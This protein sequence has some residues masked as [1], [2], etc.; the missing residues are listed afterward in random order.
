MSTRVNVNL[1]FTADTAQAKAQLKDLQ[2]TLNNLSSN[3]IKSAGM[4]GLTK[5]IQQGITAS[6]QLES[7]LSRAT[8]PDTG[9]LNL[10]QFQRGIQSAGLDLNKL[11]QDMQKLGPEGSAAFRDV[12]KA[13][14]NAEVPLQKTNGMM[15]QLWT[16]MKNTMKWQIS[17]AVIQ[18]FTKS[19]GEAF[20]YAKDLNRS[21]NDISIVTGMANEDMDKFAVRANKAAKALSTTTNEYAKASL[22]YYQQGLSGKD[23]EE[24]ANTTV[25]LAN[26]TGES[27]QQVSEWMTAIWNNFDNG[28]KSL[29]YYAD[30]IAN[31]G[32]TT[33]S[34]ADEIATGLEKF[35]AIADTVGLSY[36]YATAALATVTA[37]TRQSA[38]V[39]GTAFKTLFARIQDLELGKALD[40]GTTL[41]QYSQALKQVGVD[42]KNASGEIKSMDVVL[43]E[44]G[45]RW[46]SLAADEKVA[47]AQSVAGIRQYSQMM[48]LMDNWDSFQLNVQTAEISEGALESQQKIYEKSWEASSNRV[49]ASLEGVYDSL[50]NDDL[51]ITLNDS[52]AKLI[53]TFEIF[54]DSI[55]GLAGL[56]PLLFIGL[57]KAFGPKVSLEIRQMSQ[58][59]KD[60][61]KAAQDSALETKKWAAETYANI[62]KNTKFGPQ[63]AAENTVVKGE[64]EIQQKILNISYELT[65]QE[66]DQILALKEKVRITGD[67][68]LK[69]NEE[70]E[71]ARQLT[72]E[73]EK[74]FNSAGNSVVGKENKEAF[75]KAKQ[76][77]VERVTT[78]ATGA[79]D[80]IA[81]NDVS[82]AQA[83]LNN[84]DNSQRIS[85]LIAAAP[86]LEAFIQKLKEADA[87]SEQ[88]QQA[89]EELKKKIDELNPVSKAAKSEIQQLSKQFQELNNKSK[90][91]GKLTDSLTNIGVGIQNN[92]TYSTGINGVEKQFNED[93]EKKRDEKDGSNI[94]RRHP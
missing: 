22:I 9:K 72:I 93:V 18:G 70:K 35:A 89:L 28:S 85:S 67:L 3:K 41:G 80:L 15:S 55:N 32:A 61:S 23:V 56:L 90:I 13:I 24:R 12:T 63:A 82:E 52:L 36:E 66:Q 78:V 6:K 39:V 7:A 30:V 74:I 38:D 31:L 48:A 58:N 62:N 1:A 81:Q 60:N 44:L 64:A 2:T 42:I 37:E 51:F 92:A 20:T 83:Y 50:I 84:N 68:L 19:I 10:T 71:A 17:A 59:L 76:A 79:G 87:A 14:M 46:Q 16:T 94:Q 11:G 45:S 57:N 8:N 47:V 88:G 25:K 53:S 43:N 26:V 86:K 21:L 54:F 33:A 27:A 77:A 73:N 91:K 4:T 34:S 75:V 5:D 40:D 69:L 29:E 65:K 49:K